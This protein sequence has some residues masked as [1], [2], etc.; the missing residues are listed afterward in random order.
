M[1]DSPWG[2]P[3]DSF[4]STLQRLPSPKLDESPPTASFSLSAPSWGAEDDAWGAPSHV[5][6]PFATSTSGVSDSTPYEAN[7]SNPTR[8]DEPLPSAYEQ[9][10]PVG[11]AEGSSFNPASILPRD[12]DGQA[13]DAPAFSSPPLQSL[14]DYNAAAGFGTHA[15]PAEEDDRRLSH[16]DDRAESEG[17]GWGG[18]SPD[19][20]PISSLRLAS[21]SSPDGDSRAAGWT[22]EVDNELGDDEPPPPPLPTVEEVFAS[23]RPRRES[24]E[25]AEG[26]GDAWGSSQGWEER[27]RVEAE[28]RAQE[29]GDEPEPEQAESTGAT[30]NKATSAAARPSVENART[31]SGLSS[32]LGKFRKGAEGT[33]AKS[34]EVARDVSAAASRA[35]GQLAQ[36]A[37]EAVASA[38]AADGEPKPAAKSSWFGRKAKPAEEAAASTQKAE[39]PPKKTPAAREDDDPYTLGV[40]EVET[41]GSGRATEEEAP[42]PSA[43]GR[44]FS[45]IRKAPSSNP[46]DGSDK[47]SSPR[48]SAEGDNAIR[49]SDLD[50]LGSLSS[51]PSAASAQLDD[52]FD[53]A[54]SRAGMFGS[55]GKG[56]SAQVPVAPPED[57]FGGLIG[58]LSAAPGRPARPGNPSK[59]FDPFDPLNDSFGAVPAIPALNKPRSA[60]AS[61]PVSTARP[62]RPA[63]PLSPPPRAPAVRMAPTSPPRATSAMASFPTSH[64]TA[65]GRSAPSSTAVDTGDDSFD[66]FFDSVTSPPVSS[67]AR[68][69]PS[70]TAQAPRAA[71]PVKAAPVQPRVAAPAPRM[72]ISPPPR[73]STVSP[74][75]SVGSAPGRASTPILPLPPPPPP[76]QPVALSRP[77]SGPAP[78]KPASRLPPPLS[79]SMSSPLAPSPVSPALGAGSRPL[80][81]AAAPQTQ[82][83]SSPAGPLSQ[84]DLSFF[85]A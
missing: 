68:P 81:P 54:P 18:A 84:M 80:S 6:V 50:A 14:D 77:A 78:V 30:D 9:S 4:S 42:A 7:F 73:Q 65:P 29:R 71:Q 53:P 49:S 34:G 69:M 5:S 27:M 26:G 25:A 61:R 56:A 85:E 38:Q 52:D 15:L 13:G 70:S 16:D 79:I 24:V 60:P 28:A 57:D 58:A 10:W 11:D 12:E 45:R 23:A 40:E 1:E 21:P 39:S 51:R 74:A 67:F 83:A 31:A 22:P 2:A 59:S 76:S 82:R 48:N 20:P 64:S 37:S 75:S 55:R 41:G 33:A 35:A 47:A 3:D 62:S 72:T 66:A 19:L 44:F 43:I 8:H 46:D 63:A 36:S 32:I 17:K